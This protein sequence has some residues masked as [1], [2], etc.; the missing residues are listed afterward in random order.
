MTD[1]LPPAPPTSP[2]GPAS[3]ILP[4]RNLSET[5][6]FFEVLGFE[7]SRYDDG[8]GFINRHAIDIHYST[9]P[10]HDPWEHAGSAYI[11]VD[12]VDRV[13]AEFVERGVWL[14]PTRPPPGFGLEL[15]RRWEAGES[16]A[17]I[18]P[19]AD[20]SWGIREFVLVDPNNNALRF[21]QRVTG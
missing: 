21:G 5:L 18:T 2:E 1:S 4:A 19:L 20:E 11:A 12:D 6:S 8:Y 9:N 17:R 14:V 10:D 13:H 15:H 7:T 16:V 3:P